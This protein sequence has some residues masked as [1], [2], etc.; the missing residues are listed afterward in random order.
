VKAVAH[1]A[2][3]SEISCYRHL[4]QR[5]IRESVCGRV[6]ENPVA[7]LDPRMSRERAAVSTNA[8]PDAM[9]K[10]AVRIEH[11]AESYRTCET[12]RAKDSIARGSTDRRR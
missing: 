12:K 3:E 1:D 9:P 4:R 2:G 6:S 8:N 7:E 10:D 11:P 5:E